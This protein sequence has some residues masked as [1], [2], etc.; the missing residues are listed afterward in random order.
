MTQSTQMKWRHSEGSLARW[1]LEPQMNADAHRW[2]SERAMVELAG[3]LVEPQMAQ[4]AADEMA[5]W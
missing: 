4:M 1:S 2:N 3:S 5:A